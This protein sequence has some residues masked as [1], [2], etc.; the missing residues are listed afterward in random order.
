MNA[1]VAE[2][3]VDELKQIIQEA[4]EQ[5]LA[6]MLDDPDEG[7]ELREEIK[8]RLRRSLD[9]ERRGARE[10]AATVTGK[11]FYYDESISGD[12][13]VYP[14][15]RDGIE[16]TGS[17]VRIPSHAIDFIRGEIR[18]AG[19]IAMG[20]CRDNP[21]PGSLGEKLRQQGKSPQFLS[22]VIPLLTKEGFCT[23][24]KE[25]SRSG[26]HYLIRPDGTHH[27]QPAES[28]GRV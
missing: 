8:A 1:R 26:G 12:L 11:R 16:P 25:E 5:K 3:T 6:E 22:Y 7:L 28:R 4:V 23:H 9:A 10:V 19:E 20:A 14:T 21:S 17:K 2:L 27:G 24:F 13:I 18:K 15:D